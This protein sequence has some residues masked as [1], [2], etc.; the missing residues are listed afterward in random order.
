MAGNRK[1]SKAI[2]DLEQGGIKTIE[3]LLWVM[4]LR[5]FNIPSIKSFEHIHENQYFHGKAKRISVR[6]RPAFGRKGK[7]RVQ[8]FIMHMIVQDLLSEEIFELNWFNAYPSQKKQIEELEEFTF[9]GLVKQQK[10]RLQISNPK[11]NPAINQNEQTIIEYPTINKVSGSNLK[12]IIDKVPSHLWHEGAGSLSDKLIQNKI[13]LQ[14]AF[15]I[16]HGKDNKADQQTAINRII[17][18]EFFMNAIKA[19]VRKSNNKQL[20]S[21]TISI[22][23]EYY[24]E[25]GKTFPYQLTGD[26]ISV[27]DQIRD[28]FKQTYPMMRLVQGDVGCGKTSVAFI[29]SLMAAYAKVQTAFMCPTESLAEQHFKNLQKYSPPHLVMALLTGSSKNKNEVLGQLKE[30]KIDLLIGTH[31]LIQESVIFNHL[32]F[33]IIDEQH[34]FGVN[35]RLKLLAK[36]ENPHTLMMTATP[37]PRSLQLAQYGDLEIS[38]IRSLPVGRRGVKTRIVEEENYQ[39]YL[40]FLKTRLSMGEQIYVVAPA[41][42]ESEVLSLENVEA[43]FHEYKKFFGDYKMAKLHGQL[44]SEDKSEIMRGFEAGEIKILISTTVIEVGI[45]VKNSTVINIYNPERFG[46]STLHQLRGRVGRGEKPGFCFLVLTK[47]ISQEAM[48]RLKKLELTSD[49]FEI[50]ELDLKNRGQGDLFGANQSGHG[51]FFKIANIVED[52]EIFEKACRDLEM[53]KKEKT[54]ILNSIMSQLA[55]NMNISSSV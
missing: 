12:K 32:G 9:L 51:S 35:Q 25:I 45:D 26:Q 23:D 11:I 44:S 6:S 52:F 30:G 8:L 3:D 31:A 17:Y 33:V 47:K 28:D 53:A 41:I 46:L 22:T 48:L 19:F 49:G 24:L 15:A 38:T 21:T 39:N 54:E 4:P 40:S 2:L 20:K 29:C 18:E 37:I 5:A 1:P 42:E 10:D 13:S 34:K 27:L 55:K 14:Q 43:I 50:A 7:G 16:I 36:G